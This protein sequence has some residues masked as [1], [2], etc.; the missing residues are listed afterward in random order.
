ML[1]DRRLRLFCLSFFVLFF[2]LALIRWLGAEIRI[3]AYFNNLVLVSCFLGFGVGYFRARSS[4]PLLP[5]LMAIAG[6]VVAVGLPAR[7]GWKWGP[8][9]ASAAF[10]NFQGIAHMGEVFLERGADVMLLGVLW[11]IGLVVACVLAMDGFARRIGGEIEDFGADKRLAA[12][13]IN[14]TGSLCGILGFTFVSWLMLPPQVWF[15]ATL[16]ATLAL[17]DSRRQRVGVLAV[18]AVVV[19]VLLPPAHT[20]WS[21]YQK[22][23][24]SSEYLKVNNSDYMLLRSFEVD[25]DAEDRL[26]IDRWRLPHTLYP[27][28]QSVLIVGAG[29]GNDAAAALQFPVDRVVAVEIDPAIYAFGRSLHPDHP[30]DDPRIEVV[31]EDARQFAET[32]DERFDLIVFS[33]LDSHTSLSGFTNMRLD[34]Y[35]YT[36]ESIRAFEDLLRPDGAMFLSF[37]AM[38]PWIADRLYAN[39]AEAWGA[40]P[41]G[42]TQVRKRRNNEEVL[43][44]NFV[45]T[46]NPVVAERATELAAE[47]FDDREFSPVVPST[48]DWPYLYV[49]RPSVPRPLLLLS[50]LVLLAA[51]GVIFVLLRAHRQIRLTRLFH[52]HFFFLGA[53]FLLLEVHNVS[54]L[55]R[56][57]GTTW[58]VNALVIT[59]TLAMVLVGN[60][61]AE[62][63]DRV[64]GTATYVALGASLLL[65]VALPLEAMTQLPL[66]GWLITVIYT[67]PFLFAGLIFARSFRSEP[68]PAEA[69]GANIFGSLVGGVLELLSFAIGLDGL[70]FVA[71]A[72]YAASYRRAP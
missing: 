48:D 36:V 70:V 26:R 47:H 39:M 23:E 19:A 59:A 12:Y 43:I 58:S 15:G 44:A 28:A 18:T 13:S 1:T 25:R 61:I 49:E 7:L 9:I 17:F 21:P 40:P 33:H 56:V 10:S 8:Q 4:A 55:A 46:D 62:R 27:E 41:I 45:A 72:L 22:I 38:R 14:L 69:L 60:L 6:V 51:G 29:G 35:V 50:G 63:V 11:T 52:R 30:Y 53:A 16:L 32:S 71:L 67:L 3:F 64:G 24:V 31:I 34:D 57:F 5:S 2:E 42:L 37:W 65:G 54:R 68:H 66:G 20:T